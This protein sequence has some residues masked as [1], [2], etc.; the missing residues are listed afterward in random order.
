MVADGLNYL[1]A[2]TNVTY[3]AQGS[4]A[5]AM[6]DIPLLELAKLQ[7]FVVTNYDNSFLSAASGPF[8][9]L[10]GDGYG[11]PRLLDRR[12]NLTSEDGIIRFYVRSGT[13]GQR[14]PDPLNTNK[15]LISRGTVVTS[16]SGAVQYEVSEDVTFALNLKS[17]YVPAVSVASGEGGRI[18]PNQLTSHS[19]S[20]SDVFVTNDI[21][22]VIG[23]DVESD[24]DY[25][26]RLTRAFNTRF[27]NNGAAVQVAAS[28]VP[29]VLRSILV[30]FLRGAG[31]F[32]VLLLPRGNKLSRSVK[33]EALRAVSRATAFGISPRIKEPD[34]VPVKVTVRLRYDREVGAGSRDAIRDAVQSSILNYIGNIPLGGELIINQLRT[35][36]L[37]TNTG[38]MDMTL[39]EL[40]ID[41]HPQAIRNF[42]LEP[43][44][45]FV[46]DEKR[47]AV[48][49]I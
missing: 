37:G 4:I 46:P 49:V 45:L 40:C 44:E 5:R 28:S 30:P 12:A 32:D 26:F 29:G 47:E 35:A 11:V 10:F 25:R 41:G 13:L 19:L 8:L 31:T 6:V 17:V 15:G 48:I 38:V 2:N 39:L 16:S 24:E 36:I 7:D 34:Y 1:T 3:L 21:A 43:D 27:S 42:K 18:G 22:I 33:N 23:S 9:D 20:A 14:L